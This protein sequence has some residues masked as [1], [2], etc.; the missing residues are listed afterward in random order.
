[1]AEAE[2]IR[3]ISEVTVTREVVSLTSFQLYDSFIGVDTV[4]P[5]DVPVEWTTCTIPGIP[6]IRIEGSALGDPKKTGFKIDSSVEGTRIQN[7]HDV[8][9]DPRSTRMKL[10][11]LLR[12]LVTQTKG[13]RSGL[14]DIQFTS[15]KLA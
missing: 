9:V 7:L 6:T 12:D 2:L 14:V 3:L 1:M 5:L 10:Y 13:H 8:S 11:L 15:D 4:H